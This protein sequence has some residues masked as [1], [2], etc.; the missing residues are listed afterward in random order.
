MG[1]LNRNQLV[2]L[3]FEKLKDL[4]PNALGVHY[5]VSLSRK[6]SLKI[7]FFE[8]MILQYLKNEKQEVLIF[9]HKTVYIELSHSY[10]KKM[11]VNQSIFHLFTEVRL[12]WDPN[13]IDTETKEI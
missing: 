12:D 8:I 10:T 7:L 11:G 6:E 2:A 1:D 13:L 3:H 9:D 5:D 4:N